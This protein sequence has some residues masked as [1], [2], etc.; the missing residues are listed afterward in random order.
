[1]KARIDFIICEEGGSWF[2]HS[3][4]VPV[5]IARQ[6]NDDIISWFR[7]NGEDIDGID[8]FYIGVYWRDP[9]VDDVSSVNIMN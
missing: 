6:S 5:E 1:M 8:I 9:N 3:E 4:E 2:T 7:S